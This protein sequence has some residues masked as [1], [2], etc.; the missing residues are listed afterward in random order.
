MEASKSN[1]ELAVE[2]LVAYQRG[3]ADKAVEA[4]R[5]MAER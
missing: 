1:A 5:Q 2:A 4:G 3:D